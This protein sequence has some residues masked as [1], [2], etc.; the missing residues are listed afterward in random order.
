MKSRIYWFLTLLISISML[1]SA[2]AGASQP[3]VAPTD[4]PPEAVEEPTAVPTEAPEPTEEQVVAASDAQLDAAYMNFLSS[5]EKYNTMSMDALA[6]LLAESPVPFLLDVREVSEV[7]ENGHIEGAVVI[8]LRELGQNLDKLPSFDT[9]IVSYCGSGWR[10]TIAMTALEALGWTDVKSL[11]GGSYGGWVEA[12]NPTVSGMPVEAKVIAAAEPDPAMVM[13]IDAVLSNIP[14]GWG[15]VTVDNLATEL[16]ES[17]DFTLI[18]AR[19]PGE[20]EEKGSIDYENQVQVPLEE[21]IADKSLWPADKAAPVVVY[22]GSG[23]R[24][25][26]A[27][28]ILWSYG[29]TDIRSMKD[30]FS[31][32][33]AAGYPVMGGSAMSSSAGLDAAFQAFL[34]DMDS[35]G[36]IGLD[37]F[38]ALLAEEPPP[39]VLD[40]R[41]TSEVEEKGRIEGAVVIPLRQLGKN[42]DLLPSFD[43]PIVS[44]CGSGWRCTI[45]MTALEALGWTDVKSLKGGSYG[46]W[47]EAGYATVA[48]LP[49]EPEV[50][51]A[52]SP[53]PG[54][55]AVIDDTL[56]NIP[57]GWGGV[58]ASDLATA[59]VENPD[60]ILI[61]VRR[62]EEAA[63]NGVIDHP[64]QVQVPLEDF[65]T[66][67][68]MW[69]ADKDAP[70]VVYCGSGHRSTIAMT[71]LWAYGY[72]NVRSLKDGFGGWAAAEYPVVEAIPAP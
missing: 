60:I 17:P 72:T 11:K 39:F 31:G 51:N 50:L 70:I 35:Y 5:M 48:G 68:S 1:L 62:A 58:A 13:T 67:M 23:H 69:P 66:N 30:G 10:C 26:I 15:V 44:Y 61:D 19:T 20:V 59:L 36:T 25:T 47:V 41:E 38:N 28:T 21:F 53:D 22:C 43:T 65:I 12:G 49:A 7:K 27:M 3:T 71:I 37:D 34:G 29:Y 9:P 8:P 52:A 56:S 24:S 2:C 57:E 4:V 14:E 46:G 45:G 18:D 42:L 40:V 55:V 32:W 16:V 33:T 63:E 64:N 54:L 6:E